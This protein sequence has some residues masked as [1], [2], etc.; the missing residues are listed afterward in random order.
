MGLIPYVR[1]GKR[2]VIALG[3]FGC[4]IGKLPEADG[5]L[6]DDM[7]DPNRPTSSVPDI[8]DSGFGE[9]PLPQGLLEPR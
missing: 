8:P 9:R 5:T 1:L 7:R 3:A 6:F 2:C 4:A